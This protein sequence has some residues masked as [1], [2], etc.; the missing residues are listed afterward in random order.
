M[1][2]APEPTNKAESFDENVDYFVGVHFEEPKPPRRPRKNQGKVHYRK[3][4][5]TQESCCGLTTYREFPVRFGKKPDR[6]TCKTCRRVAGLGAV[7]EKSPK[8][9]APPAEKPTIWDRLRN[10]SE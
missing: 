10:E 2:Q 4:G 7:P 1:K 6:V 9:K 8:A 5:F 3:A